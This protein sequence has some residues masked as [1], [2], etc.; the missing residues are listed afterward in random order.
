MCVCVYRHSLNVVHLSICKSRTSMDIIHEFQ[1]NGNPW[2]G[3]E[4]GR[5]K[6]MTSSF[7]I[8][9]SSKANMTKG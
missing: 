3:K 5:R 7:L 4:K 2:G 8:E 1:D 6:R 9:K